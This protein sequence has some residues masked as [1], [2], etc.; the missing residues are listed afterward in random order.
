MK[1]TP[2]L[3]AAMYTFLRQC[4]P[5]CKLGL[6]PAHTVRFRVVSSKVIHADFGIENG[7]PTI[8]VSRNGAEFLNTLAAAMCHEIIHL[9]QYQT[10]DRETHG[11]RFQ[12]KA[13]K[14]CAL[15]GFDPQTF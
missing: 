8:R 13:K 7:K 10:G 12:R 14:I 2:D 4:E 9:D 15:F 6:P 1:L 5:F 11:P 3:L